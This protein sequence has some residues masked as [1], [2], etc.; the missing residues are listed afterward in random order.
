MICRKKYIECNLSLKE[1]FPGRHFTSGPIVR[2]TIMQATNHPKGR[3]IFQGTIIRWTN[4][5][6][7]SY[8]PEQLPVVREESS[9]GQL[10]RR[11]FSSGVFV[12]KTKFYLFIEFLSVGKVICFRKSIQCILAAKGNV[13]INL[14]YL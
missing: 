8:P 3:G 1:I 10:S 7:G 12:R 5:L 9:M 11:Q 4:F 6:G 13:K 2:G 14:T